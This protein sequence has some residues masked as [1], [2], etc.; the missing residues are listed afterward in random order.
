MLKVPAGNTASVRR[1]PDKNGSKTILNNSISC[2]ETFSFYYNKLFK[3]QELKTLED[4]YDYHNKSADRFHDSQCLT[5]VLLFDI[6]VSNDNTG[7]VISPAYS[8]FIENLPI[9][10]I[11]TT[12]S[13]KNREDVPHIHVDVAKHYSSNFIII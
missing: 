4:Q 10:Y 8:T 5:L 6:S 1:S 12:K 11:V 2:I 13:L 7:R 9:Q 3:H